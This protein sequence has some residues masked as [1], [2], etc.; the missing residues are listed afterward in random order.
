MNERCD[1]PV[2]HRPAWISLVEAEHVV[3]IGKR[4]RV[5][6]LGIERATVELGNRGNGG[7]DAHVLRPVSEFPPRHIVFDN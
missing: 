7:V 2:H 3:T 6:L 5:A 1:V 4:Y